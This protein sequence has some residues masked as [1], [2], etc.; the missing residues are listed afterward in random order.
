MSRRSK[1]LTLYLSHNMPKAMLN[2]TYWE[3]F[4][5][6]HPRENVINVYL[7]GKVLLNVFFSELKPIQILITNFGLTTETVLVIWKLFLIF[8][9]DFVL[10]NFTK[11]LFR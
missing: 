2:I 11:N 4:C 1:S 6:R 3:Y 5:N 9:F 10:L 8:I 7:R